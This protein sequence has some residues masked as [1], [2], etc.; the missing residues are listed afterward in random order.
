MI[1][2]RKHLFQLLLLLLVLQPC[3]SANDKRPNIIFLLTDD[4]STYSMGCY[5]NS[6]VKTPQMDL[7]ASDGL[8]FDNHYNTT[9][10]CMAS[11]ASIMT[12]MY[13]Y[14]AGCNFS[15]GGL[16]VEKFNQTYP[17]LLRKGGYFTGFA[18]K[19]GIDGIDKPE[20]YFDVYGGGKGQSSY[21]T[22]RNAPMKKYAKEYPH[23]TLSYAAFSKDF[24]KE[25]VAKKKPF[26]LS[27]SFKAPHKPATPDPQFDYVYKNATFTKPKNY[28]REHG[29][30]FSKQSKADRQY[31]RFHSWNYSDKYDEVMATYYQQIYGVDVALGMIREELK[32]QGV[33]DNTIIIFTS[34]NGFFCGSHGYGSK[35][36][37][38][39]E[40][41]RCP[42]IVY[43]PRH[44][45]SGKKQ[46]SP[47]LTGNIDFAATILDLAGLPVPG[48]MDG[49][50]LMPILDEPQQVFHEQLSLINVWGA[51]ATHYLGVVTKKAKYIYWGYEGEQGMTATEELFDVENDGL[52]LSNLAVNPEYNELLDDMRG[53]YDEALNSWKTEA[54]NYND[55]ERFGVLFDRNMSWVDK[56]RLAPKSPK[57]KKKS[58]H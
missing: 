10:I 58:K 50:S 44:S 29:E 9:A 49:K 32:A 3:L 27:I 18:G 2:I 13:E 20:A 48:N 56:E 19:F 16:T 37:P 30:H 12:G 26:C 7:L 36:L 6:D 52:E 21:A 53:R 25:A 23:S 15:H 31:E 55:Y 51:P 45:I 17:V 33:E 34:D 28:G 11:R 22:A 42:L 4:Q 8:I 40:S 38:Y 43:D 57:K 14:K 24:I 1:K 35:V 41:T 5:G 54:I 39:E 47:A 46:R